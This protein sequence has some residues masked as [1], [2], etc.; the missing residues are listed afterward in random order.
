M[1]TYTLNGIRMHYE[2]VCMCTIGIYLMYY[3]SDHIYRAQLNKVN[4]GYSKM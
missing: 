4:R 1:Q 2:A 3:Q